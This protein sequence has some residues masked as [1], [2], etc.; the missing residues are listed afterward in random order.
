MILSI[1]I[2]IGVSK[3]GIKDKRKNI[4]HGRYSTALILPANL[5]KG[6]TSTL[7]ANRVILVDPRGEIC[8]D[9]LLE[10]LEVYIEPAFWP[11]LKRKEETNNA[12]QL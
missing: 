10:F 3:M 11:W 4:K 12:K 1:V 9:D 8:A 5:K 6:A 7:A 2:L